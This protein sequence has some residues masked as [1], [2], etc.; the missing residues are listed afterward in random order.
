MKHPCTPAVKNRAKTSRRRSLRLAAVVGVQVEL[1][2]L[3]HER[4]ARVCAGALVVERLLG[5]LV[6]GVEEVLLVNTVVGDGLLDADEV[7]ELLELRDEV[8]EDLLVVLASMPQY[9]A[10]SA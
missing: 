3:A 10:I 8:L 5:H 4:V 2:D 1:L 7:L 6:E 9:L